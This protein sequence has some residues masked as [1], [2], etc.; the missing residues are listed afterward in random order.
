VND[1]NART[2]T[3]RRE[4]QEIE[5][6]EKALGSER[7]SDEELCIGSWTIERYRNPYVAK[8]LPVD[9]LFK[10]VGNVVGASVL[11]CGCGDGEF[12]TILG[13]LGARVTGVDI[14]ETLTRI[15]SERARV[16]GVSDRVRFV[17][18][19]IHS[20]PFPSEHFDLVFGKGVL[21]HV[22]IALSAGEIH[23]VLKPGGRAVF[24]EPIALSRSFQA[25]RQSRL[26]KT[27]IKENRITPDEE[28]VT[29]EQIESFARPFTSFNVRE[30]QLFSRLERVVGTGRLYGMINRID[31]ALLGAIPPLRR[32]GRLAIM[33]FI[34]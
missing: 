6:Y 4:R 34:K 1:R 20:L 23:R 5:A 17:R 33:E 18:A 22:D 15:A 32:F 9:L 11:D 26:V 14:S 30:V 27:F 28:P 16:N 19:S 3:D 29:P 7:P 25:L 12:S 10:I 8:K 31:V 2:D 21:H 24:E 13:L